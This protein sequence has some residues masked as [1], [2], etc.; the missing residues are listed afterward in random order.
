MKVLLV[1]PS[2]PGYYQEKVPPLGLGYIGAYLVREGHE[3]RLLDMALKGSK[4][5]E[6]E[7]AEFGPD[8]TGITGL[9]S[10][11]GAV[12]EC[13]EIAKRHS[14]LVIFGGVHASAISSF[15]LEDCK[16]IDV[17]CKG[18]GEIALSSLLLE[19]KPDGLPGL[20]Y[21]SDG[22][23]KGA[24]PQRITSLS[25]LPH[26]WS[27]LT[28]SDYDGNMINGILKP[29]GRQS[30]SVI[31]SRG[32]PYRCSFCSASQ[33]QGRQIRLRS[34]D[35]IISELEELHLQGVQEV[36]F[37][38]D[39]FTFY[40]EHAESICDAIS[41]S[42]LEMYWTLPNGIRADRVNTRLLRKMKDTGCYYFGI[43]IES[44]SEKVL[45]MMHKE[46]SLDKAKET[47]RECD[48]LGIVTQGF[49]LVGYPEET[50][51]DL[52]KTLNYIRSSKL[53][54]V[55]IN[56]VMLYPG[57]ELF[58]RV[59]DTK[60]VDWSSLHRYK[61]NTSLPRYTSLY[62]KYMYLRFYLDPIRMFKHIRKFRTRNQWTSLFG[63]LKTLVSEVGR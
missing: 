35:D 32:C 23:I 37:M 20:Y 34:A 24:S 19:G 57:S 39:N 53:D 45:R 11:Y 17:V 52:R 47:I 13:A 40:N 55:S 9:S 1:N 51:D 30:V 31:S 50:K 56:Q 62:S 58:D 21:R 42:G 43:G 22:G 25:E 63:G 54:R 49:I 15:I 60:T 59:C 61:F 7:M 12:K 41:R 33:A 4:S 46:L 28:L 2:F 38:D 6:A 27:F 5:L 48:R 26:P 18:E 29:R 14:K 10:Q 8:V 16:D 44:G 3:V 36:Q